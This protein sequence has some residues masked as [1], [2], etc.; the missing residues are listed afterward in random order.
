LFIEPARYSGAQWL[1]IVLFFLFDTTLFPTLVISIS[2]VKLPFQ[3]AHKFTSTFYTQG[4]AFGRIELGLQPAT[5]HLSS[6]DTHHYSG[7]PSRRDKL[8][9]PNGSALGIFNPMAAPWVLG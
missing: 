5:M 6:F 4:V 1:I 7:I 3:G 2:E 9:H 8:Y